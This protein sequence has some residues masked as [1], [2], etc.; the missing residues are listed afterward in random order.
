MD[1]FIYRDREF[2]CED[3]ALRNI[4]RE[5]GTPTYVYS[6]ATL[7]RHL[8]HLKEAFASYPTLPCFAVK[9]NGNLSLLR[10]IFSHGFGADIVSVGE[11]ERVARAG[12]KMN[13]VVYSGVGKRKE[14]LIAAIE[15]GILSINIESAFEVDGIEAIA[16]ERGIKANVS[17]RVNPNIDAKTHPKITTGLLS[18]KFGLTEDEM[19]HLATR[20]S[21]SSH[22]EL[23]GIACHIGSQ[24]LDLSPMRDAATKMVTLA[25]KLQQNGHALQ[26]M[27]FGGGLGIRYHNEQ[28]P[29]MSAYAST[30]IEAIRPTGLRLVVEP[31]RVLVGNCGIL[32]TQILGIKRTPQKSFMIVDG[33]MNDLIR[34]SLYDAYHEILPVQTSPN[35]GEKF[36]VVGPVCESGDF[37]GR[38]RTLPSCAAGEFLAIKSAGAYGASMASNYNSRPRAAEVLVD[39]AGYRVIRSRENIDTLLHNEALVVDHLSVN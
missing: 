32:L 33:A 3:V 21:N 25:Q 13:E 35:E 11:L 31:G 19:L 27:S 38:D 20:I 26:F 39:G 18:S 14:E 37:L 29:S 23:V 9:A 6:K 1:H 7:V 2:Y 4:A 17:L 34:P 8:V 12:A 15:R 10:E 5:V 22:L 16:A 36:D 30:L 28:P 24:M